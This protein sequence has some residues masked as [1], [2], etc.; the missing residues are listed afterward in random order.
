MYNDE[1]EQLIDAALADC[2]L[3]EKEKQ[4]LF[5]KA[6]LM[7]IDLDEFEMVLDA[8]LVKLQNAEKEKA[9]AAA[10]KSNKYGDVRKCPQCGAVIQAYL[11]K[12][13]DCGF[14]FSNVEANSVIA[15]LSAKLLEI[16]NKANS[17]SGV[18]KLLSLG[19]DKEEK[20]EC[21]RSFAIPNT[22][23][24]MLEFLAFAV[25]QVNSFIDEE[26]STELSI[27][28]KAYKSK[29]LEI[30]SRAERSLINDKLAMDEINKYKQILS[31]I[32]KAIKKKRLK[33]KLTW[34]FVA[35][36]FVLFWVALIVA[37]NMGYL[38]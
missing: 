21:I 20:A 25:P 18:D 35:I 10:P 17:K 30:I 34:I 8:R 4:I 37:D 28:Q 1:L 16:E 3:T 36:G 22:K 11:A 19:D 14:E 26:V 31:S 38:D 15:Q 29:C 23:L 6:Q 12:C 7:G 2:V 32:D 13:P 27:C 9:A 5:K 24:D 33:E